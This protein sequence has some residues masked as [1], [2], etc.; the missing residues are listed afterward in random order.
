M[1]LPTITR[2]NNCLYLT[3]DLGDMNI[4]D[5]AK[6]I[7]DFCNKETKLFETEIDRSILNIFERYGINVCSTDKSVLKRAFGILK[8]NGIEI[9][10]EDIY[11][12]SDLDNT[13]FVKYTRNHLT[14]V[15]EENRYIQCGVCV[16][17]KK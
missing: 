17:E 7:V 1:N 11:E 2:D 12:N 4:Y 16:K 5:K 10:V 6:A 14:I 9:V 13:E 3:Q 8:D 15:L